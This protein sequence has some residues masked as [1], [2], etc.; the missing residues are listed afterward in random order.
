MTANGA[1]VAF[2]R[3]YDLS[4]ILRHYPRLVLAMSRIAALQGAEAAGC[5][6]DLKAGRR[7]SSSAV[8]HYGGTRKVASDAWRYRSAV[9]P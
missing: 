4:T 6:C 3:S 8:N 5:I 1:R 2:L 7:W 9:R